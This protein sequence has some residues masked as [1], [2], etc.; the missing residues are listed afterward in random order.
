[1]R[2]DGTV[3]VKATAR[4]FGDVVAGN[5]A[6]EEGAVIVGNAKIGVAPRTRTN[7]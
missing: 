2:A 7:D 6:V 1:L 4:M 5:L 3:L